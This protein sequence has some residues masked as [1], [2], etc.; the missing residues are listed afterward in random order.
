MSTLGRRLSMRTS[1]SDWVSHLSTTIWQ[2]CAYQRRWLCM[3]LCLCRPCV[4][5]KRFRW[6]VDMPF[7]YVCIYRYRYMYM[8]I[9]ISIYISLSIYI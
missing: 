5:L 7:I 6:F 4:S 3:E 2:S 8:Y 1:A 9:Y